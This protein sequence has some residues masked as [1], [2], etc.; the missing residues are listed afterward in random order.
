[1]LKVGTSGYSFPDWKGTV[2]PLDIAN[3][4]MLTYYAYEL[5]FNTVEINYTYYRQPS[6]R[7]LAAITR[8]VPPD[9]D[10]TIKAY[11]EMTHEIFDENWHIKDNAEA[12]EIYREGITPLVE[13]K[14]LGCVLFQ[15]PTSFYPK[16]ENR[17]YILTCKE[18]LP[19]VPLVIEFRN[20]AWIKDWTF[21]FLEENKLGYCCVDEPALPKLVPFVPRITSSTAYFRFHGRNKNWFNVP[22]SERYNYLYSDKELKT[23]V[24]I[25][26]SADKASEKTYCFF[27]NCHAGSAAK[28]ARRIK[29]LLGLIDQLEEPKPEE[30]REGPEQ[31]D[32][33]P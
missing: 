10:F 25:I 2:Y 20:K 22:T 4:D 13:E 21:E 9:F 5:K 16:G 33:F 27:N 1:M 17:D 28:N 24:P 7:T 23:F 30:K 19:H 15:F 14:R 12:F 3:R 8:K 6:A 18:R 29:S 11:K 26:K 32:L 31:L